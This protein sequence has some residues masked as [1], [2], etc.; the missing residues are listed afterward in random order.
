MNGRKIVG[1][2]V[3]LQMLQSTARKLLKAQLDQGP[4]YDLHAVAEALD[5]QVHEENIAGALG[6]VRRRDNGYD[7][8]VNATLSEERKR[9]TLGHELGHVVL[10][11][12]A[13]DGLPV[14]L[15]RYSK[16][17]CPPGL[18]EDPAEEALCNWFSAELLM[19]EHDVAELLRESGGSPR[20]IYDIHCTFR[21]SLHAAATR[22]M[23]VKGTPKTSSISLWDCSTPWPT[24]HWWVGRRPVSRAERD[25]IE[26]LVTA[27]KSARDAKPAAAK[28][29]SGNHVPCKVRN[30]KTV[31]VQFF[32]NG[33]WMLVSIRKGESPRN[34]L[35]QTA[36]PSAPV[37]EP[38]PAE[39]RM[40]SA[41]PERQLQLFSR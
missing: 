32:R 18:E 3:Q 26:G 23:T 36:S 20:A 31:D 22:V 10:M 11:R 9:F 27:V 33:R 30:K 19:P 5:V 16:D 13:E 8:F 4:P 40:R 29:S 1:N 37:S 24:T 25:T 38:L 12:A 35:N 39:S 21:V 34:A 41:A 28:S 6:Y 2:L 17:G 14:N 7:V 15:V